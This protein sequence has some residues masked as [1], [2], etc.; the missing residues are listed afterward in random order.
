MTFL[1]S[2]HK[3]WAQQAIARGETSILTKALNTLEKNLIEVALTHTH[4]H[5]QE[6]AHV[7]GCGR[8]TLTRKIKELFNQ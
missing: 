7:L 2:K 3:Q 5:R 8:N 4:D 6:A 1:L